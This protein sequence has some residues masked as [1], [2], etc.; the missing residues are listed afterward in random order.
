MVMSK[1]KRLLMLG[2]AAA[3]PL[4]LCACG[5]GSGDS[6]PEASP[7]AAAGEVKEAAIPDG[8]KLSAVCPD[9]WNDFSDETSSTWTYSLYFSIADTAG[10]YSKPYFLIVYSDDVTTVSG[11]GEAVSIESNGATWTG[12]YDSEYKSFNITKALDDKGSVT[13]MSVGMEENDSIFKAVLA[14]VG[15]ARG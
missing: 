10:V 9:G 8:G 15:V 11:A 13:L 12:F 14:S 3:L 1:M 4:A 6:K 5:S 2:M 7:S